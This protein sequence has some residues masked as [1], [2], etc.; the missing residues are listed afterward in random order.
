MAGKGVD[1]AKKLLG[2]GQIGGSLGPDGD[3]LKA[4]FGYGFGVTLHKQ[5]K[6]R[7]EV[8]LETTTKHPKGSSLRSMPNVEVAVK[9]TIKV[10]GATIYSKSQPL[11]RELGSK[12]VD[13]AKRLRD[14][15]NGLN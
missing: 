12:A 9:A 6:L 2:K 11:N 1:G 4:T 8:G 7:V 5:S 3:D 14:R 10:A 15:R 13:G